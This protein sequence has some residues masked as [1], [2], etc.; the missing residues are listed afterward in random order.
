M[1]P[2]TSLTWYQLHPKSGCCRALFRVHN[3]MFLCSHPASRTGN[4][5]IWALSS[6]L[7]IHSDWIAQFPYPLLN[8]SLG[9]EGACMLIGSSWVTWSCSYSW[10]PRD[11][12]TET[13]AFS[14]TGNAR[15]EPA[16]VWDTCHWR[17]L[18]TLLPRREDIALRT[19]VVS[20][21]LPD[22]P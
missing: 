21:K 16:H 15:T 11:P 17:K 7:E 9:S 18:S 3:H 4:V 6:S 20:G 1:L 13:G 5:L 10:D 8:Q 22:Y 19:D 2:L 14:E 12:H